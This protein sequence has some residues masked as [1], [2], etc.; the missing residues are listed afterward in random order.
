MRSEAEGDDDESLRHQNENSC[1][2]PE[3]DRKK[4]ETEVERTIRPRGI[5]FSSSELKRS[6]SRKVARSLS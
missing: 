6:E 5:R 2:D 1:P 3:F 4:R